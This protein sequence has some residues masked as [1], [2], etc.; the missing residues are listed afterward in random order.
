[1][2]KLVKSNLLVLVLILVIPTVCFGLTYDG[3]FNPG[4]LTHW[5]ILSFYPCSEVKGNFHVIVENPDKSSAIKTAKIVLVY[6]GEGEFLII[7]YSYELNGVKYIFE[8]DQ[9]IGH[10]K[11]VKPKLTPIRWPENRGEIWKILTF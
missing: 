8:L 9:E 4:D 6:L 1:M 3:E 5:K 7:A 11:Q 2:K 10:Y